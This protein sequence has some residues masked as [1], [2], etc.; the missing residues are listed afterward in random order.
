MAERV[1]IR[2][3]ACSQKY[4]VSPTVVGRRARCQTCRTEFRISATQ[5]LDDDTIVA[6]ITEDDPSSESVMGSTGIFQQPPAATPAPSPQATR[7]PAPPV[8]TPPEAPAPEKVRVRLLRIDADGAHF[9]FPAAALAD[10]DLR[11]AFPRKCVG[12]GAKTALNVHLLHWPERMSQ[13]DAAR[14]REHEDAVV[15]M[16]DAFEQPSTAALLR[17]LPASRHIGPPF[18][19]P[20]P[21]F[22][23]NRCH[24]S[25]EV[26]G[27]VLT[28][29]P[30]EL[31]RLTIASLGVAV[32][33]YR[34]NGGREHPDYRRLVEERDLRRDPYHELSADTRH[35][36]TQWFES[37]GGERFVRFYPD[38]EFC[39]T[40]VGAAG[41]VLTNQRL[42]FRKY[43][44]YRTYPLSAPG[45]M[46][47]RRAAKHAAIDVS[48]EGH[49]SAT[50]QLRTNDA[51]R[52][53]ADLQAVHCRWRITK[54]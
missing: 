31:C 26:H 15:G 23:C 1:V 16:L 48:A 38:V 9:E 27:R 4:R 51:D 18:N 3:P 28:H 35:R 40:E 19:L 49:Q 8:P 43:T 39:R 30:A 22:T 24:A 41:V 53:L 5:P 6:W 44:V 47:V 36:L 7:T 20:F 32:D 2:C 50:F 25:W 42:V 13:Q 11:N 52:L 29:G 12:C 14:W 33:F 21:I 34:A 46:E 54:L 17:Q 45:R 37:R 10:E